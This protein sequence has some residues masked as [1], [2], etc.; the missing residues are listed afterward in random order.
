MLRSLTYLGWIAT[1]ADE[2]GMAAKADQYRAIAKRM[3]DRYLR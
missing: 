2:P 3:I 1:R